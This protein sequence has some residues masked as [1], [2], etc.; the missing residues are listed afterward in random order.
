MLGGKALENWAN[1]R[2]NELGHMLKS[3]SEMSRE[4]ERVV[5]AEM[6]TFAMANMIGQV[7]L[8]KRVFAKKGAEVNEFKDMVVE[9]MTVAGYFNIG[10]FIPL[11]AWLDLQGI[12]R[13]MKNLHKKF[14]AL[15]TKMFDEHKETSYERKG[16]EDFLDVVMAN[17]DNSEGER[18]ST[19]NI[20]ALL[21]V[22]YSKYLCHLNLLETTLLEKWMKKSI[23]IN[24]LYHPIKFDRN[25]I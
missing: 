5:V 2:A 19:T 4:G 10:D 13:G 18:L 3:M 9:L 24:L 15:L 8:S 22:C 12:E 21:L 6:L 1:V 11:L 23:Y 20:K 16:K 14:D 7:I 25:N 17:R